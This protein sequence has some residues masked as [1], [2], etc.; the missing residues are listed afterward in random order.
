MPVKGHISFTGFKPWEIKVADITDVWKQTSMYNAPLVCMCESLGL[1]SPK[2]DIDGSQVS[3][4]YWKEGDAG[5]D[6]IAK[7]CSKDVIAV[8]NIARMLRFEPILEVKGDAIV[9]VDVELTPAEE[10]VK[11]KEVAKVKAKLPPLFVRSLNTGHITEADE[12]TI[13]SRIKRSSK[14]ERER[15]VEIVK[16]VYGK[17]EVDENFINLIRTTK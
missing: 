10:K 4:T 15:V 5:L 8:A 11:A 6:R 1:P 14:I 16:A 17:Q 12:L 9:D 13:L 3:S 7:Y 2:S